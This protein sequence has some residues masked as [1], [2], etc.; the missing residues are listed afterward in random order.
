MSE[1]TKVEVFPIPNPKSK[2]IGIGKI[3]INNDLS[4]D[5]VKIISGSKGWFVAMPSVHNKK[6]DKYVDIVI[7]SKELRN[8]ITEAVL[9]D[10]RTKVDGKTSSSQSEPE[11]DDLPF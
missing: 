8:K 6:S 1:V 7:A 3:T 10:F 9:E 11:D 5:G 2:I 4:V